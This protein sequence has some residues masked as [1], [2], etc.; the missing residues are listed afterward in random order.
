VADGKPVDTEVAV[1]SIAR[2]LQQVLPSS[3]FGKLVARRY[4]E[5]AVIVSADRDTAARLS[6]VLVSALSTVK[7]HRSL[8]RFHALGGLGIKAL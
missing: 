5:V 4:G 7:E 8:I 6:K 2:L 1:R 3:S